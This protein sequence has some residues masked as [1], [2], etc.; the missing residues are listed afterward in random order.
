MGGSGSGRKSQNK[1]VLDESEIRGEKG[2]TVFSEPP[3]QPKNSSKSKKTKSPGVGLPEAKQKINLLFGTLARL[4]G[5]DYTYT[6]ADYEGEAAA[7]VRLGQKFSIVNYVITLMD[8]VFV[9]AGLIQK[10]LKLPVKKA[11]P[12]QPKA[13]GQVVNINRG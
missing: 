8:P 11:Q 13:P 5:R 3:D 1:N 2:E 4:L 7:L 12:D 9:V 10:F 6:E